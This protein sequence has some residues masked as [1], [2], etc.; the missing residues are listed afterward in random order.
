M[1]TGLK[2]QKTNKHTRRPVSEHNPRLISLNVF[3]LNFYLQISKLSQDIH[4]K[5]GDID[6]VSTILL[7]L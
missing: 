1:K 3:V 7:T 5:I 4:S 2:M 6:E